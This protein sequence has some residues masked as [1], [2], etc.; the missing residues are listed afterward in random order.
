[1]YQQTTYESC[2]A[3]SL[4]IAAGKRPTKGVELKILNHSLRF[5][6][7]S[8]VVGHMDYISR[9]YKIKF[10]LYLENAAL[11]KLWKKIKFDKRILM[12]RA[13]VNEKFLS[14]LLKQ[15]HVVCY[16]DNFVLHG[17][18]HYPHY[19]VVMKKFDNKYKIYDP[20][21]GKIKTI[22]ERILLKGISMLRNHLLFSPQLIQV[23]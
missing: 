1:M 8:F 6:K 3:C 13:K 23:V 21:D 11:L 22:D 12:K 10:V 14:K 19:V 7:E 4:L 17:V 18:V 16:I 5:S 20:W 15:G 9:K 2:L